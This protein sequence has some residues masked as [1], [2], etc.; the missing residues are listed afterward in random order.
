MDQIILVKPAADEPKTTPLTSAAILKYDADICVNNGT[1]PDS[2][3]TAAPGG[4]TGVSG[5]NGGSTSNTEDSAGTVSVASLVSVV[6]ALVA[7][8]L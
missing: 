2:G 6:I 3:S 1:P 7:M 4:S 5:G 8:L